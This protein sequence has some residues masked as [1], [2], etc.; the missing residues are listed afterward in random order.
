VEPCYQELD[1]AE[2]GVEARKST[3]IRKFEKK[4]VWQELTRDI[5][6]KIALRKVVNMGTE[7]ISRKRRTTQD[8]QRLRLNLGRKITGNVE[9]T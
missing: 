5:T 9:L 3:R 4:H 6:G 8:K 2:Q 7:L 1:R